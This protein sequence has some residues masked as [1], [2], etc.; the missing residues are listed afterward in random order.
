MF[1]SLRKKL[2]ESVQKLTK[3]V[4]KPVEEAPKIEKPKPVPEVKEIPQKE[5]PKE[6][7]PPEPVKK[8]PPH[9]KKPEKTI[10]EAPTPP[11]PVKEKSR[12]PIPEAPPPPEPKPE[13]IPEEMPEKKGAFTRFREAVTTRP[14]SEKDI[15]DFFSDLELELMQSNVAVEVVDF[16]K[17]SL[18]EKLAGK[19][20]KRGETEK[21]IQ[22]ALEESLLA[23]VDHGSIDLE[24]LVKEKKPLRCVILGFNGS[25]KTT[26]IAKLAKFMKD[27]GYKPVLAAGDTFRAASIEQLEV[28]AN[29][30]DVKIIKQQYGSDA[31]AVVFDAIKHAETSGA[32]IVLADTAGRMHTDK[33]L[34]D[35][36]KKVIRVNNPDFKILVLDSLTGNDAIEQAKNFNAAVGVD[37]VVMTK[38]DVNEKG[39]SIL[40]VC[41]AIKKPILFLGMGQD[42]NDLKL[43]NPQEFV[44]SLLE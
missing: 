43:F 6:V 16:L 21:F 7:K 23:A 30:L 2:K 8:E 24:K 42:Y 37:A 14:L 4:E 5:A 29:K 26:T 40:S 39:G 11:E 25:G 17:Q 35:E 15:D 9:E 36:L 1:G 33:N 10:P 22:T 12:E 28:H 18:K 34:M 20:I 27:R 3:K 44:K 41:Y 19:Q 38:V 31:A 32:D 13:P